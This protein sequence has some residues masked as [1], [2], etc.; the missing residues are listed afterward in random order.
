MAEELTFPELMR[1]L[2][3]GDANAAAE[4]FRLYVHRLRGL[5]QQELSAR[6]RAMLSGSD[7]AQEVL[8]SFLR[9]QAH[10]PYDLNSA[11][12]LWGLLAEIT[13]RKCGKWNRHFAARKRGVPTVSLTGDASGADWEV[14]DSAP[15]PDDA[16]VLAETVAELYRGL[17]DNERAICELR[18]QGYQGR[19]IAAQL[20]LTE[21]TVSRKLG[22]IKDRLQR[23]CAPPE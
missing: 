18:L 23:L 9:R 3:A 5:A 10:D 1:R 21:E 8:N 16:L 19:E 15:T 12:A 7:V 14:S 4:V 11:D 2:E 13:F 6:C 20:N 17:K 22:R